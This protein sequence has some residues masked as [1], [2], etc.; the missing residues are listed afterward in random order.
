[1]AVLSGLCPK[2]RYRQMRRILLSVF[3]VR[4]IWKIMCSWPCARWVQR[5]CLSQDD[6][7]LS[8]AHRTVR[9]VRCGRTFSSR[10]AQSCLGGRSRYHTLP[11]FRGGAQRPHPLP[12]PIAPLGTSAAPIGTK[13][14]KP[15][16]SAKAEKTCSIFGSSLVRQAAHLS[17]CTCVPPTGLRDFLKK[18]SGLAGGFFVV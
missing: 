12:L 15:S 8:A 18:T 6:V 14:G 3:T 9:T 2:E 7:S 4:Y 10:N 17:A 11:L 16:P 13:K 1:M 5:G